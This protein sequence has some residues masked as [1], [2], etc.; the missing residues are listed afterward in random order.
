[1]AALA[2]PSQLKKVSLP[3]VDQSWGAWTSGS[4]PRHEDE[5][6]DEHPP[7]SSSGQE[8]KGTREADW[9]RGSKETR[10]TRGTKETNS[11]PGRPAGRKPRDEAGNIW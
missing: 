11:N 7:L 2:A 4:Y 6:F 1:M 3:T 9:T 10:E 5:M 8:R